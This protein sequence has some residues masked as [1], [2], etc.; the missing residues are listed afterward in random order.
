MSQVDLDINR[1]VRTVLVKHWIDLG[2]LSVRSNDGKL[3][4]RG[5][6]QRIAGVNEE[7]TS[8]IVDSMFAEMKR[9]RNVRQVYPALE[10]WSNDTG[11]WTPIGGTKAPSGGQQLAPQSS[12]RFEIK[13]KTGGS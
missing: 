4:I 12:E 10:N 9:I 2:R 11:S 1:C 5:A 8:A 3:Y 7:L 6:L 13:Q